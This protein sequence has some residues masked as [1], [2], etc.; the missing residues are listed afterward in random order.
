[1]QTFYYCSE[2]RTIIIGKSVSQISVYA[3]ADCS[4]IRNIICR[5]LVPPTLM[6]N[7]F[8]NVRTTIP[9]NIPCGTTSAYSSVW[10]YFSN[11]VELTIHSLTV[12]AADSTMGSAMVTIQHS[13]QDSTAVIEAMPNCGYE[14]YG[15]NDGN[16]SNPRTVVVTQDTS[17][18][19]YFGFIPLDTIFISDTVLVHDTVFVDNYISDT[20]YIH[21]TIFTEP[22][23]IGDMKLIDAMIYARDGQIVVEGSD[24][25]PVSL[26]D[27]AGRLLATRRGE[28]LHRGTPLQFDAPASG[29]YLVRIG[30]RIT[31]KVV[32]VK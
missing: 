19:A 4:N 24:D 12:T 8:R 31:R 25:E 1:M 17:F 23:G 22:G 32:V 18:T 26:Y 30:N 20:I 9:V 11:F 28:D 14:F 21:D 7:A 16:I 5:G 2:L 27:L 13:C 6:T 10:N 3:F 15:W 29:A